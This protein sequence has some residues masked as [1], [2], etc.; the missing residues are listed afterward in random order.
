MH[1]DAIHV[2]KCNE[3][4]T[5]EEKDVA[6]RTCIFAHCKPI[7]YNENYTGDVIKSIKFEHQN[8]FLNWHIL[9]EN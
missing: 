7:K 8:M 2:C 1:C 4:K 9:K 5:E 3:K 6:E